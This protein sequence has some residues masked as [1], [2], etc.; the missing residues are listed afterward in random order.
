MLKV[1]FP[2]FLVDR[3]LA[4]IFDAFGVRGSECVRV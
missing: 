4:T 2:F 1:F 3:R